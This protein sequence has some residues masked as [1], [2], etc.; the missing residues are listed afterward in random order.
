M[1]KT[2]FSRVATCRCSYIKCEE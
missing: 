2:L 1:H